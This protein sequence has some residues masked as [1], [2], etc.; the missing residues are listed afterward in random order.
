MIPLTQ[1]RPTARRRRWPVAAAT[2]LCLLT[3][4]GAPTSDGPVTEPAGDLPERPAQA[5]QLNILD[6]A[7]NLQLTQGMIDEYVGENSDIVSRVTYQ[8]ATSPELVGKIKAQQDANRVDIDIV[9]T[10]VDGLAA[11]VE[12]GLWTELVPRYAD[13]LPGMKL[14]L[15]GAAKMQE[16]AK[17]YGVT[18][19][20][21]PSGPLI[22]YLPANVPNPP[23]TVTMTTGCRLEMSSM[24]RRSSS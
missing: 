11:G 4:C 17:G 2:A 6:V 9:L 22:E 24:S 8:K 15:P 5:V 12:Q 10:G 7:G 3:A 14:Y 18:V 1:P 20:Y 21:Y 23:T 13:R 19:T 16:L